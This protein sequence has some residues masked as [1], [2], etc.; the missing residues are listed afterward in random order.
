MV[1]WIKIGEIDYPS[2]IHH[3]DIICITLVMAAKWE[4]MHFS[5]FAS[6]PGQEMAQEKAQEMRDDMS[7]E[8]SRVEE[9]IAAIG[10]GAESGF[11]R[12]MT[13][14]MKEGSLSEKDKALIALAC[15]AA[16]RCDQCIRRHKKMALLKGASRE[17]MLE[18][19]AI[20]G[21][22][23]MGSGYNTAALL[24]DED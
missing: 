8:E 10:G 2:R 17:E 16:V 12:L 14:I 5:Y 21:L 24:L 23:R 19:A 15:S 22:V 4:H 11:Q 20:A 3:I 18:A 13:E 7:A 1:I 6:L 9:F